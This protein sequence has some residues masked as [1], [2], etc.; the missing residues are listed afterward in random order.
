MCFQEVEMK[1]SLK[2]L[3]EFMTSHGFEG[4]VQEKKGVEVGNAT[5]FKRKHCELVWSQHRSRSLLV[6]LRLRGGHDVYIANLHLEAG[7][8]AYDHS[9]RNSQL[10]SSLRRLQERKPAYTIVCG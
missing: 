2:P 4:V 9:Q 7:D 1:K 6:G 8:E 5:F 10:V 3:R